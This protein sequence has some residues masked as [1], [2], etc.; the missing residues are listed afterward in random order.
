MKWLYAVTFVS[1]GALVACGDAE[2]S[3]GQGGSSASG[4]TMATTGTGMGGMGGM[5]AGGMGGAG[6]AGGAMM[7]DGQGDCQKCSDCAI[8]G[9]CADEDMAYAKLPNAQAFRTCV[10]PCAQPMDVMCLDKC[11]K[12][13]PAECAAFNVVGKCVVCNNCYKDCDGAGQMCPM[14]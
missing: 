3:G 12:M 9:D 1:L 13:Y 4:T 5:G 6:G 2:P 11:C 7:C 14:P 8:K 10:E